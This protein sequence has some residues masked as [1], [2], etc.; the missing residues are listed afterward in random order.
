MRLRPSQLIELR[1]V[2]VRGNFCRV[3]QGLVAPCTQPERGRTRFENHLLCKDP[4][5]PWPE[6]SSSWWDAQ[7]V[8]HTCES[9]LCAFHGL[10]CDRFRIESEGYR[11]LQKQSHLPPGKL[12]EFAAAIHGGQRPACFDASTLG[13]AAR[14]HRLHN[15]VRTLATS[16][17]QQFC[18]RLLT[19]N[20]VQGKPGFFACALAT[21]TAA[22][23]TARGS[24][25]HAGRNMCWLWLPNLCN[26]R[27]ATVASATS[28]RAWG[29]ARSHGVCHGPPFV[30]FRQHRTLL[31]VLG[32]CDNL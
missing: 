11:C 1:Q 23:A 22:A 19:L 31:H 12:R 17:S 29:Y 4:S 7:R 8:R 18:H 30:A 32:G 14:C 5:L 20:I 6:N 15:D 28:R 9:D 10:W 27:P 25:Q 24:T 26:K 21:G 2:V 16:Q 3:S 13:F